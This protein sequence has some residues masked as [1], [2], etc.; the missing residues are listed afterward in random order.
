[1]L[2]LQKN[3]NAWIKTITGIILKIASNFF[4][5]FQAL[6]DHPSNSD[7]H[8]PQG[9]CSKLPSYLLFFFTGFLHVMTLGIIK[10]LIGCDFVF[11]YYQTCKNY[12][13]FHISKSYTIADTYEISVPK[14]CIYITYHSRFISKLG[15]KQMSC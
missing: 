7:K 3:S 13:N 6:S 12:I 14:R 5:G 8:S 15:Y 1:M 10:L 2:H 9:L 11:Y 4:L